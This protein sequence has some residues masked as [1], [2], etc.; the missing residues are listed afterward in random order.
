MV[1]LHDFVFVRKQSCGSPEVTPRREGEKTVSAQL[2]RRASDVNT[3]ALLTVAGSVTWLS[4]SWLTHVIASI[5][6]DSWG[7]LISGLLFYPVAFIHGTG[8][9]FGA[10]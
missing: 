7:L 9:W 1:A 6:S 3:K 8:V 4:A 5:E 2:Y 10:W